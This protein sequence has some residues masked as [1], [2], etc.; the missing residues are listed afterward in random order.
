MLFHM[1]TGH[2]DIVFCEF[3]ALVHFSIELS[4]LLIWRSFHI[5]S[6]YK[7]FVGYYIADIVSTLN[8]LL[9]LLMLSFDEEIFFNFNIFQ[10][11]NFL[12]IVNTFNIF[13][14]SKVMMI[15]F[16]LFLWKIYSFFSVPFKFSFLLELKYSMR[17]RDQDTFFQ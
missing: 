7:S 3:K 10:L 16:C 1:F 14:N 12:V 11:I 15:F 17:C 13:V 6:R 8:C 4:V 2:L 9:N 5:Y